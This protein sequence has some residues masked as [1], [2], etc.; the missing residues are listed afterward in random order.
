METQWTPTEA[1]VH[2]IEVEVTDGLNTGTD[3]ARIYVTE[4]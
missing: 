3:T 4:Q 2:R 1:G